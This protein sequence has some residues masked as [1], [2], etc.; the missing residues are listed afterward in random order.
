VRNLPPDVN[1]GD[2]VNLG[3]PFGTV[4]NVL[5]LKTKGQAFIQ[6]ADIG[7]SMAALQY[8]TSYPPAVKGRV[9]YFA[10]S[11]RDEIESP[12]KQKETPNAI[13][14]VTVFNP[15]YPITIDIMHQVFSRYGFIQKIVIFQKQSLQ[16]LIQFNDMASASAAKKALD[17]QSLYTGCCTLRIEFSNLQ[18]LTVKYNGDK[19]R[20]FTNPSLPPPPEGNRNPG[21]VPAGYPGYPGVPGVPAGYP[22]YPPQPGA[23]AA[24]SYY[25]GYQ[26]A[27]PAADPSAGGT[28]GSVVLVSNLD[29][30]RTLP[31]ELFTL[32]GVYGD[33]TK[34]KILY[35]K[36]DSALVQFAHPQFASTASQHLTNTP[37]RG[38]SLHVSLS[39]HAAVAAPKAGVEQDTA[40]PARP[41]YGDYANHPLHRFKNPLSKH[42]QHINPPSAVL[43]LSNLPGTTTEE[44]LAN[45][46]GRYGTLVAVKFLPDKKPLPGQPAPTTP[47]DRK[48]A[49]VQFSHVG[50]AVEALVQLHNYQAGT[51]IN[52]KVSFSKNNPSSVSGEPALGAGESVPP[53]PAGLA[54]SPEYSMPPPPVGLQH[55]YGV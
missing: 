29:P 37:W 43:H 40:N 42:A 5:Q 12:N 55:Q 25:P 1:E 9:A 52:V 50:E 17:G 31:D 23:D 24:Q 19:S 15:V 41:L 47:K 6:F 35:N 3:V 45:L 26:P 10:Y 49:L 46:C 44:E 11:T 27:Y 38:R 4:V 7:S 21:G 32:F 8:Y 28:P 54:S 14:L 16:V 18:A 53:M 48:M 39:K 20:D 51:G 33:V 30:D 36:K 34:V 13:L 2:L 22:G